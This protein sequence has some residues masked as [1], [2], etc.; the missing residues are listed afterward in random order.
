MGLGLNLGV[1]PSG[2]DF[3]ASIDASYDVWGPVAVVAGA[4]VAADGG[5][6]LTPGGQVGVRAI[7]RIFDMDVSLRGLVMGGRGRDRAAV[8]AALNDC[9]DD[10]VAKVSDRVVSRAYVGPVVGVRARYGWLF[11]EGGSLWRVGLDPQPSL[12]GVVGVTIIGR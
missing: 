8:A 6:G 12:Y 3:H 9:L 10:D 4:H 5:S 7:A 1:G 2:S 11:V